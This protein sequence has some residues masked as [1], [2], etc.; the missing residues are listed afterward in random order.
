MAYATNADIITI[1]GEQVLNAVA[2]RDG[3]N[4]QSYEAVAA[5]LDAA[6]A[7]ID[8][9]IGNRYTVPLTAPPPYIRQVCVDITVYR[10]AL[11]VGPRTDEMRLRYKD[12][13]EYLR[14]V[15]KGTID[16]P[17]TGGTD[18]GGG[19]GNPAGTGARVIGAKR[20]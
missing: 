2:S 19:T 11:D 15:S 13:I 10:L 20:G 3:S 4:R 14:D 1:Y 12:A 7:E 9:Y 17:V 16:L 6:S 8:T 18:P 5:A